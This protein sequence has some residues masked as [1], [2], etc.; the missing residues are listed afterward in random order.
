MKILV[1]GGGGREHALLW[2]LHK[3]NPEAKYH[4]APGNGGIAQIAQCHSVKAADVGGQVALAKKLE[5]DLVIPACDDPLVAG[6]IDRLEKG[7]IPAF[8]PSKAA[9]QI[10]GSKV[11]CKELLLRNQIPTAKLFAIESSPKRAK[12]LVRS[13]FSGNQGCV[14]KADGLALGKGVRICREEQ[15]ALKAIDDF[16]VK[17]IH[18]PSGEI[19]LIEEILEG[20]ECSIFVIT[21]GETIK[22]L[23]PARDHKPIFRIFGKS[24]GPNTGGMASYSPVSDVTPQLLDQILKA[25]IRP[26]ILALAKEECPFT[27]I[28]Y[29][30]LMLT[31]EG[32][33]VLEFN[34]RFGDPETQV[35]LPLLENNLLELIWA[36]QTKDGSLEK[37]PLRWSNQTAICIVLAS[38]GYPWEHYETGFPIRGLKGFPDERNIIFHAGTSLKDG[39][40][41]T[42]GGR[43]LGSVGISPYPNTALHFAYYGA[44]RINFPGRYFVQELGDFVR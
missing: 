36:A 33:K 12:K 44:E 2:K 21:D 35:I 34:C 25:I 41:V 26:T 14:I 37:I 20:P 4:C 19:I 40:F 17:K 10:E 11:F 7:G 8:G 30:G 18:G 42:A 29:A 1:I 22:C 24:W 32:P 31:K 9:A 16:M 28:L 15:A 43:V 38:Y 27:G 5:P 39:Q 23:P 13:V 6:I 3:D